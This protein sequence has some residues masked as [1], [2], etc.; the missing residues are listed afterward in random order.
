MKADT[1]P[2]LCTCLCTLV[3]FQ[4]W[5]TPVLGEL[6]EVWQCS[7]PEAVLGRSL[8][9]VAAAA[10]VSTPFMFEKE[11]CTPWLVPSD[12]SKKVPKA[13]FDLAGCTLALLI[14]PMLAVAVTPLMLMVL[15]P[16]EECTVIP[17]GGGAWLLPVMAVLRRVLTF[18]RV[19]DV[20]WKGFE[21]MNGDWVDH[22]P[23]MVLC[24]L[25]MPCEA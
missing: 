25:Q 11:A 22:M 4:R 8:P 19:S 10:A 13:L 7:P 12:C 3:S 21:R 16:L 24:T 20:A 2:Q 17:G 1:A 15:L 6:Q 23:V 18:V 14:S 9:P 5:Q